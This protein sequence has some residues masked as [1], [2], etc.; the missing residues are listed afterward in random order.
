MIFAG[1]GHS[2]SL[3]DIKPEL[4]SKALLSIKDNLRK[5]EQL[6]YLRGQGTADEQAARVSG[7]DTLKDCL[8]QAKYVQECVFENLEVKQNI[9]KQLD[10]LVTDDVIL[11]SSTSCIL[12]SLISENLKHKSNFIVAHP[13]ST[14]AV[15]SCSPIYYRRF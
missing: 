13:V 12:P 2:V 15:S 14:R 5:Y 3:Y 6:G 11:A 9:F 4:V 10:T 1:S 8:S 7:S